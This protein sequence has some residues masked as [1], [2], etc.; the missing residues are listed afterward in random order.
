MEKQK[1]NK[2]QCLKAKEEMAREDKI[3][4]FNFE[5]Q[6]KI[7]ETSRNKIEAIKLRS[8]AKLF[9]YKVFSFFSSE[10]KNFAP[11]KSRKRLI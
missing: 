10:K 6:K 3:G 4:V 5:F 2:Q 1:Q 11:R 8:E 9:F 7:S